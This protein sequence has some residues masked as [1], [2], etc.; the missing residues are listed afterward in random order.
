MKKV[1]ITGAAGF[2]GSALCDVLKKD[3]S[4]IGM[5]N[6]TKPP[7]CGAVWEQADITDDAAVDR[8]CREHMPDT[9]VHCAGIA[10]QKVG[11]VDV[12]SY[13]RINSKA[14]EY[15]AKAV[16]NSNSNARFIFLS[17]ICVYGETDLEMPVSEEAEC[18][19]SSDYAKSKLDAEKRLDALSS[20]S[21]EKKTVILRLAPVYGK[22]WSLNLDRRILMPR[23]L[24][25]VKFGNGQQRMSALARGNLVEFIVYL[26]TQEPG[27]SNGNTIINVCDTDA[28]TF[29]RMIH[30]YRA[31][32]RHPSGPVVRIPLWTVFLATRIAGLV[33][34]GKRGWLHSCYDK[35]ASSLV[36][37]N[38]RMLATGFKPI[39]SLE[40]VFKLE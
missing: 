30:V 25:Y 26:L 9:V 22:E 28:Y 8:I 34:Y 17:S 32:G 13:M 35:L 2:I 15:L 36:F 40:S 7:A 11:A 12:N 27:R 10:H 16:F 37:D 20:G 6:L 31:S 14:T 1:L 29:N 21:S 38:T 3:F 18:R 5:D 23:R 4:I 33:F 19:P 24:G 39:H